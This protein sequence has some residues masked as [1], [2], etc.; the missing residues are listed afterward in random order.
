MLQSFN[1]HLFAVWRGVGYHRR[2]RNVPR[3]LC[4]YY[5]VLLVVSQ[6]S[7]L[8]IL[9]SSLKRLCVAVGVSVL[10]L[11]QQVIVTHGLACPCPTPHS[12]SPHHVVRSS[13]S[14]ATLRTAFLAYR[15]NRTC[16][17]C[18]AYGMCYT[19]HL[20]FIAY[21]IQH[22]ENSQEGIFMYVLTSLNM[23]V[24]RA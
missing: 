10:C 18:D 16:T 20:R 9:A 15:N 7:L 22:F 23:Y 1:R 14:A 5:V 24:A 8:F 19:A 11:W 3:R 13:K 6:R 12:T 17:R 4:N 2:G 21:S